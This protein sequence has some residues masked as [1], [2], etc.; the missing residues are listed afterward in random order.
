[1]FKPKKSKKAPLRVGQERR[2]PNRCLGD[3]E[4]AFLEKN[5]AALFS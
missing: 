3:L 5:R 1:L 2:F 4:I